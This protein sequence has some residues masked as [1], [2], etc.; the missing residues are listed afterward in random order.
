MLFLIC[1]KLGL[2]TNSK[3]SILTSD[4]IIKLVKSI[5]NSHLLINSNLKKSRI[6]VAKKLLQIKTYKG[7]RKLRSLPIRGQRTHT[8]ANTASKFRY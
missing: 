2:S 6:I 8:N 4:Q 5:E 7:I 3:L 1:K